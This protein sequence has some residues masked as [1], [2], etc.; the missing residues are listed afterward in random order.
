MRKRLVETREELTP[1]EDQIARLARD[2][3][4]NGEIGAR[5]FISPRTVEY[6]LHKVFTKLGIRLAA[7]RPRAAA[8]TKRGA[9]CLTV[10]DGRRGRDVLKAI[11]SSAGAG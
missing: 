9:G 11:G 8:R 4:S 3:L 6:H 2:G 5:L 1:Q 10:S 7:A